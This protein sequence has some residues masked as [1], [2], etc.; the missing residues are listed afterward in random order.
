LRNRLFV[1]RKLEYLFIFFLLLEINF[2]EIIFILL[3]IY[4]YR[5]NILF[6][7]K[8][9]KNDYKKKILILRNIQFFINKLNFEFNLFFK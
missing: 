6:L 3:H 4:F 7:I 9:K 8:Y 5:E 1:N 2:L